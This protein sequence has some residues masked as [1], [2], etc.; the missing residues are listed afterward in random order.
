MMFHI[1]M[2]Y[3]GDNDLAMDVVHDSFISLWEK[4]EMLDFS[5]EKKLR[6]LIAHIVKGKAIDL[7]R[8]RNHEVSDELRDELLGQHEDIYFETENLDHILGQLDHASAELIRM[9]FVMD[10]PYDI[11]AN[12]LSIKEAAARKRVNRA[13]IKLQQVYEEIRHDET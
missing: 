6:G 8:K 1:A 7:I 9:R 11:I 13:K 3:L 4:Y 5:N 10:L 2:K 12:I